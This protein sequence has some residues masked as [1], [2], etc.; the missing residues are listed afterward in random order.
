VAS[1]LEEERKRFEEKAF[2]QWCSQAF[3]PTGPLYTLSGT[4]LL[5]Q[6]LS[7]VHDPATEYLES[8]TELSGF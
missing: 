5:C 4:K 3:I 8:P 6:H 7:P 1:Y 2:P